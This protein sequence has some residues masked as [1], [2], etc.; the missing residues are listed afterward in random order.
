M[1]IDYKIRELFQECY[2]PFGRIVLDSGVLSRKLP[3]VINKLKA[4]KVSEYKEILCEFARD[5][6][7]DK[8]VN[9]DLPDF[10]QYPVPIRYGYATHVR[11]LMN[12]NE[13][14]GR[15]SA[16]EVA[17]KIA[18]TIA[19]LDEI[20][21]R[22]EKRGVGTD[23]RTQ[24]PPYQKTRKVRFGEEQKEDELLRRQTV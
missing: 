10:K 14:E 8:T 11:T 9:V 13:T 5:S 3:E 4:S 24:K 22:G 15:D 1:D 12:K 18:V 19:N 20:L 23:Y 6:W 17:I 21:I 2:L 16:I 7:V